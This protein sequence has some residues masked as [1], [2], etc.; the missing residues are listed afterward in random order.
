MSRHILLL[1]LFS[2]AVQA[3]IRPIYYGGGDGQDCEETSQSTPTPT[4]ESTPSEV[5]PK[6]S[7][8][9]PEGWNLTTRSPSQFN[10]N[11]GYLCTKFISSPNAISV[12]AS[13]NLCTEQDAALTA[14]ENEEERQ[15]IL[16]EAK[17]HIITDLKHATG[18]VA[19]AGDRLKQCVT[20]NNPALLDENMKTP[21]CNDKKLEYTL[22]ASANTNAEFLWNSWALNEPSHNMWQY[23]S[24]DCLQMVIKPTDPNRNGK[25]NDIYC[26]LNAAPNNPTDT[27]FMNYGAYCGKPV[28]IEATI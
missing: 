20:G 25:I 28:D 12:N 16:E 4:S 1:L 14:F 15:R 6:T 13:S 2:A 5:T 26:L 24:E 7:Y 17:K 19:I 8:S 18:S 3:F 23:E 11:S 27:S 21:P 22:P 9:C 10:D